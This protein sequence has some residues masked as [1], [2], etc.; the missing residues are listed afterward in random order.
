MNF[1]R[2]TAELNRPGELSHRLVFYAVQ[3]WCDFRFGVVGFWFIK[4][5]GEKM[6][7]PFGGKLRKGH[8]GTTLS[9]K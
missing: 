6:R 4:R 5:G 9:S 3:D 7:A 1:S 2:A 8:C